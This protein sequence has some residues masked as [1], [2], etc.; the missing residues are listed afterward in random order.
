MGHQYLQGFE[1]TSHWTGDGA[2]IAGDGCPPLEV[3]SLSTRELGGPRWFPEAL[4]AAALE[5]DV[6]DGALRLARRAGL[7]VLLYES[8][9]V[10]LLTSEDGQRCLRGIDLR[11]RVIVQGGPKEAQAVE[12][13]MAAAFEESS[14][15]AALQVT[16]ELHATVI[17]DRRPAGTQPN[18]H[19]GDPRSAER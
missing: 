5:A 16:P 19:R 18:P 7:R 8:N 13:L 11:P 10:V 6:M 3:S 2:L 9:A 12:L 1:T 14:I 15:R 4:L 17:C